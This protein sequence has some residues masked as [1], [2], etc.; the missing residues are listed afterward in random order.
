MTRRHAATITRDWPLFPT[1]EPG[2]EVD[3]TRGWSPGYVYLGDLNGPL[4]HLVMT[5]R[6]WMWLPIAIVGSLG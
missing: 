2:F 4:N 1:I 5:H 6:P 3:R